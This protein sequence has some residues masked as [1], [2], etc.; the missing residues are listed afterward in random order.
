MRKS[1]AFLAFAAVAM[2]LV[3]LTSCSTLN[4]TKTETTVSVSGSGTVNLEA[5]L[6]K[7]S[8]SVEEVEETT[9]LAQQKANQ[10]MSAILSILRS[11]GIENKDISTTSLNFGTQYEWINGASVK[12][13]ESV[14]QSVY[15][16]MRD[17]DSFSALADALG[18][19]LS[20]FSFN[21]V[22]FDSSKK[23]EA[24]AKARELAYENALAKAQ[25]YASC[26]GMKIGQPTFISEGSSSYGSY[27][28]ANAGAMYLV[29]ESAAAADYSTEAPSGLLSVTVYV[30]VSFSLDN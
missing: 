18:T 7:F 27:K 16:T 10:K 29:A 19:Q 28:Y 14:S 25:L 26:A 1:K 15:V 30:D 22:S 11:F 9:A 4:K 21:N 2:A 13:G 20:G 12:T 6:V 24:T 8:I 17:I 23:D 5:D 3:M